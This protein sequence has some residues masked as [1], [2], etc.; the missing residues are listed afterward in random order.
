MYIQ[1]S[2]VEFSLA[3]K[4]KEMTYQFLIQNFIINNNYKYVAQY[5]SNLYN[6]NYDKE[7]AK[8]DYDS[9]FINFFMKEALLDYK[10]VFF[11]FF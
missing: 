6:E 10:I 2:G 9:Y 11:S 5:I 7:V 8:D 1:A 3:E 4:N